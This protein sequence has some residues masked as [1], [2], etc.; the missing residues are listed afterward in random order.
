MTTSPR[1][2][3]FVVLQNLNAEMA[4]AFDF[5]ESSEK[6]LRYLPVLVN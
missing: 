2:G 5:T 1:S 4:A 3:L 6:K